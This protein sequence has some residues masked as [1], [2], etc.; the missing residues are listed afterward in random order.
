MPFASGVP[1]MLSLAHLSHPRGGA[2]IG[3]SCGV[4]G[5]NGSAHPRVRSAQPG[6]GRV[7]THVDSDVVN[8]SGLGPLRWLSTQYSCHGW[9][10]PVAPRIGTT[11]PAVLSIADALACC[12]VCGVLGGFGLDPAA[13]TASFRIHTALRAGGQSAGGTPAGSTYLVGYGAGGVGLGFAPRCAAGVGLAR[14]A[15]CGTFD[16]FGALD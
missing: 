8:S 16:R 4:D 15:A 11:T 13:A 14:A 10:H 2:T 3:G 12:C 1:W 7:P 6:G 9:S 5:S